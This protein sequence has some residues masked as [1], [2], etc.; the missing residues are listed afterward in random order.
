MQAFSLGEGQAGRGPADCDGASM[1]LSRT[2]VRPLGLRGDARPLSMVISLKRDGESFTKENLLPVLS[3]SGIPMCR[4]AVQR[5]EIV[6]FESGN[7]LVYVVSDLLAKENL[8]FLTALAPAIT[9][10]LNKVKG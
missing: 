5:S 1:Q 9:D 10:V 3:D 7:H 4:S 8:A 6:G 2:K